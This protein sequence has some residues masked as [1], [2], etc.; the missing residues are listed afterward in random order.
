MKSGISKFSAW[1][2]CCLSRGSH[3]PLGYNDL[4]SLEAE[5]G[6]ESFAG[7]T[8]VFR[9]G[10]QAA[11][12]HVVRT[13]T[14]ELCCNLAGRRATLQILQPGDVFGDVPA[15][16]EQP[17][18][19]DARAIEDCTVLSLDA[20][21]LFKLLQTRPLVARRWFVS[22]AERMAALQQRLIDLL[23]GGLEAQ[24]ASLLL[25]QADRTGQ[26]TMTQADL[27]AMLGVQRS[28]VQRVLKDLQTANLVDLRYRRIDLVD[29]GGLASLIT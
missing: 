27:A 25:R 12:V 14:V 28:S 9:Q 17:E 19:F 16:L 5:M 15:F 21:S 18:P 23:S 22:M 20:D 1:L 7:G 6:T 13:G 3:S 10:D 8:F 4:A 26:V 11:R 2:A 29:S 24:L